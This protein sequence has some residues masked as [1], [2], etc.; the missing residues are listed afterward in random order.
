MGPVLGSVGDCL[1][2]EPAKNWLKRL[3]LFWGAGAAP[4]VTELIAGAV[5]VGSCNV[6]LNKYSQNTLTTLQPYNIKISKTR[7][8]ST[9]H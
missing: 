1:A 2:S 5:G 6:W 9:K 8:T 4:S 7:M 3:P